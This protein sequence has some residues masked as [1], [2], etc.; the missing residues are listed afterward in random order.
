MTRQELIEEIVGSIMEWDDSKDRLGKLANRIQRET[1]AD[2][3]RKERQQIRS[4]ER[5]LHQLM[6]PKGTP[7]MKA[8]VYSRVKADRIKQLAKQGKVKRV[9]GRWVVVK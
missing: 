4:D 9:N 1:D 6:F 5:E 2:A 7:Y 8:G 3:R